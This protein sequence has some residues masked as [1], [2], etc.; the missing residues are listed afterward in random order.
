MIA[1][2]FCI[3]A[4]YLLGSIPFAYLAGRWAKGIDLRTVG[5]G[6]LGFTNAWRTLGPKWSLPVLLFDVLKG[7]VAVW[8]AQGLRPDNELLAILCGLIAIMGHNWT[9]YLGFRGGG[10]GVAATAGVFLALT[11]ISFLLALLV[12]LSTLYLTRIMSV[13]SI[14]LA[15]SLVFAQLGLRIIQ[16]THAP[17]DAVFYVSILVASIIVI[18]HRSNIRRLWNGTETKFV[19]KK[20]EENKSLWK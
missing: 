12:F 20:E 15:I 5:S 16:S 8:L 1:S 6:N 7:A 17:S 11:P 19:I 4:A 10:K 2:F 13:S 9:I 18:R 14:L 3:I